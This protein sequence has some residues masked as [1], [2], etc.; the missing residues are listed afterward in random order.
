MEGRKRRR[1]EQKTIP[2]LRTYKIENVDHCKLP[3]M[4][5]ILE[6]GNISLLCAPGKIRIQRPLLAGSASAL[7]FCNY[8]SLRLRE[9]DDGPDAINSDDPPES[10]LMVVEKSILR[11]ALNILDGTKVRLLTLRVFEDRLK[12][13]AYNAG[14]RE[15]SDAEVSVSVS[16]EDIVLRDRGAEIKYGKMIYLTGKEIAEKITNAG[17]ELSI[18]HEPDQHRL[19]FATQA[20][21]KNL[22]VAGYLP[23]PSEEESKYL[24]KEQDKQLLIALKQAGEGAV[25]L[26]AIELANDK[27]E[28]FRDSFG[29]NGT[30]LI[31]KFI[32]LFKG[33]AKIQMK[34]ELACPISFSGDLSPQESIR[35]YIAGKIPEDEQN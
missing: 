11:K 20:Q 2:P 25:V 27:D 26:D 31:N 32:A 24:L 8:P 13:T 35:L 6:S 28:E 18:W 15:E 34:F 23:L 1:D 21:A 30:K 14:L 12:L 10:Y 5:D 29:E 4:L 19:K 3:Q 9:G 22:K 33:E 17:N 7:L 16:T